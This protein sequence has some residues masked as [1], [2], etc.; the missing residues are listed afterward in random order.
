MTTHAAK[1]APRAKNS[2]PPDAR[3][4][5]GDAAPRPLKPR[6][7]LFVLLLTVFGLWVA[8]LL[9]MYFTT[10]YPHRNGGLH[11]PSPS[12]RPEPDRAGPGSSAAEFPTR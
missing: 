9:V 6:R 5:P 4:T 8:A 10:V 11:E 2:Q 12:Q 7:G 3:P 1:P